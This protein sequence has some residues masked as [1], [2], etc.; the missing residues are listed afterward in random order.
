V[1]AARSSSATATTGTADPAG[2]PACGRF[3]PTPSGPLHF[4]SLVAAVASWL[5]ARAQRGRW[6]VRIED[7]DPPRERPGAAEDI[8]RTLER[9]ALS[10]DGPVLR[11][12]ARHEAYA[13]AL[14]QLARQGLV[15][16]CGCPRSALAALQVN[17]GRASGEDLHHP[18]RCLPR[19]TPPGPG[20]I[21]RRFRAPDAE[22]CFED[23][24]QGR[25]CTN[26]AQ[27]TGDF[28]LQRRD[29]LYAY[30]LAV[31]VDDEAQG[32]TDVVRGAD[33]LS[34]TPRQLLLQRALGLRTPRYLHV[35]VVLGPDGSKLSKSADAPA[36][37]GA[38]PAAQLV[39]ALRFLHQEPPPGLAD[40]GPSTVLSWATQHWNPAA[41]HGFAAEAPGAEPPDVSTRTTED[42]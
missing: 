3:A 14:E 10:W 39:A 21:A 17:A 40:A 34:S 30:Q 2:R 20:E 6:L 26:V 13:E 15:N 41:I 32:V 25:V 11:Q 16:D 9:L 7:L 23:R 5:D 1:N 8:L 36:L 38:P 35:P 37:A 19:A 33:L 24:V 28:V 27:T 22:V 12:S 31:V 18:P 4:G 29:G 42:P